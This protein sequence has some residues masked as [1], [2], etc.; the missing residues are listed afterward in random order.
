MEA[1]RRATASDLPR[2]ADLCRMARDELAPMRGGQ[3]LLAREAQRESIE[4]SLAADLED[5]ERGVWAGTIDG[6]IVGYSIGHVE[7]LGRLDDGLPGRLGVIDDLFVEPDARAVGVG[8]AMME[9]MLDWF[10][11]RGC[12]GVD[13]LALPGHRSSKNFFEGS[14]FTARLLVM[15]RRLDG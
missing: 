6:T 9:T 11:G 13:A 10:K 3:L 2:L 12:R 14:G 15:H 8:E 1:A 5:P 4:A 7:Q